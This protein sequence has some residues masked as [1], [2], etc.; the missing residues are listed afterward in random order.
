MRFNRDARQK[1]I[2]ALQAIGKPDVIRH[3]ELLALDGQVDRFTTV[4]IGL[5]YGTDRHPSTA[6]V[7]QWLTAGEDTEENAAWRLRLAP[8]ASGSKTS[9]PNQRRTMNS[10]RVRDGK[11]GGSINTV[12]ANISG[13][14]IAA[15]IVATA[16]ME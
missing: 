12:A 11:I 6:F 4:D 1:W 8:L 5:M 2:A 14:A 16:P 9:N 13:R 10:Q 15:I 7:R 3:L